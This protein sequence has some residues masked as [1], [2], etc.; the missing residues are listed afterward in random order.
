VPKGCTP[1]VDGAYHDGEWG[2]AACVTLSGANDPVYVKYSGSTLYLAWPMTPA[3]GCPAEL[4]FSSDGSM[5]L[6][7]QQLNLGI[8]DDPGTMVGDGIQ[9]NSQSNGSWTMPGTVASGIA[10]ANPLPLPMF[11]N[12]VTYELAIPFSQLG[13]T[14]GQAKSVGFGVS[15]SMGGVWPAGISV[16]MGMLQP[17]NPGDWGTLTSSGNWQ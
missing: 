7:G 9:S 10:I 15:H 8:F 17:A 1:T 4:V 3:C 6:D 2:D 5:M 16:P 11:P 14:A 12:P 13:I